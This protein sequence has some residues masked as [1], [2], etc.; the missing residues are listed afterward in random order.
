MFAA[1]TLAYPC[2]LALLCT[3][4]GLLVDRLSGSGL[5]LALLPAI[6]AATLIG[7]SQLTTHFSA[8]APA[9]PYVLAAVALIG[10]GAG[11]PRLLALAEAWR[12]ER[13]AT[14][15]DARARARAG[16]R[17][18]ADAGPRGQASTRA[19]RQAG[20]AAFVYV[21]ALAPVLAA[22]RPT[23]SSFQALTD[24]A[25]HMLGADY[26]IRH[27]QDYG[28]L[29]LTNSYGQY[30]K[31]YY[32][33]GYP[34]GAD[35]LFGGSSF[36]VGLPLIWTFQ[37]F[38]AFMLATAVGPALVL[39]RGMGLAGAWSALAAV[40]AILGALV[41]GYEL[42]ASI[43]EI[44]ALAMILTLGAL[45]VQHARW[46][47]SRPAGVASFALVLA[48]GVSALGV[49]F[50]AWG[51]AA[52]SVVAV[53]AVRDVR[54]GRARAGHLAGVAGLGL[55]IFAL[56]ALSTWAQL[57]GSL[58]VAHGIATTN[59]PGN[60]TGSLEPAQ[61]FGTWLAGSYQQTP[62]GSLLALTYLIAALTLALAVLGVRRIVSLGELDLAGWAALTIAVGIGLCIYAT[63][64]V[65]AKAIM[66][67]S[68]VIVLLAWAGIAWL[69]GTASR[70]GR[71]ARNSAG[72]GS[73]GGS[74]PAGP[75]TARALPGPGLALAAGIPTARALPGPG[76]AVAA[77]LAA[78]AIVGGVAVS[79]AMQYHASNLAPTA[80][81][82]ELAAIEE[83]FAGQGPTL[84]ASF[85]EYTL[86]ELRHM[87]V[88]GLDFMYPPVGLRTMKGHGYPVDLDRVPAAAWSRYPLVL[89]PRDPTASEPPAAYRLVWQGAYYQ[90]WARRPGAPIAI[91]HLGLPSTRPAPCPSIAR[92]ARTAAAG[93]G[94]LVAAMAPETIRLDIAGGK[95][96]AWRYTHPGLLMDGAGHLTSAFALPRS[97]LWDVW[98]KGEIMPTVTVTI[99][100]RRIASIGGELSGN[101]H[102]PEPTVPVPAR[103]SAGSHTLTIARNGKV[104]LAPGAG[105]WAILHE[106]FL[107]PAIDA[108]DR[109]VAVTPS[110]WRALCGGRYDWIEAVLGS[111]LDS[112][113]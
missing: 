88:G 24:S 21:A 70:T 92:L 111:G 104:N 94:H 38:N 16:S 112:G 8:A 5:A 103:L 11:W 39:S 52:V 20:V 100:G 86:Y 7:V 28:G 82:E 89:T 2:V 81:Y 76:L 63:A 57:S 33:T 48:A 26:L 107:T 12:R 99:D 50:G 78:V 79:D 29:D 35:T 109:R 68:P 97:G 13:R 54:A 42:V 102:N 90:V 77:M 51:L 31:A 91:A 14:G 74:S 58:Q 106:A 41:Y 66:L 46:L 110:R 98:L 25:F 71:R 43:K 75:P 80:R 85:D 59:N 83:R 61:V 3:G 34:S 95:H 53:A 9:T 73:A 22:G 37:P 30:L 55:A 45:T 62:T 47:W 40:T 64:W 17:G 1:T 72:P 93:G 27:G 87:D 44:V 32:P 18:E 101:P 4:A 69:R 67:T 56:A 36:L 19:L 65:S 23:F 60:L 84:V 96:P 105:G 49:G 15:T 108:I 10:F 6:G 113:A